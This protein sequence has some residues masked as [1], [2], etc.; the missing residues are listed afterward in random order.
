MTLPFVEAWPQLG[1]NDITFCRGGR[2]GN[3]VPTSLHIVGGNGR[4]GCVGTAP[5]CRPPPGCRARP[6]KKLPKVEAD[7]IGKMRL[8]ECKQ[9]LVLA[10]PSVSILSNAVPTR[11]GHCGGNGG[12][13][14]PVLGVETIVLPICNI[15]LY[16]CCNLSLLFPVTHNS[17]M[18]S[19]LP[20]KF[21]FVKMCKTGR[22]RFYTTNQFTDFTI[23]SR[24]LSKKIFCRCM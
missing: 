4:Q 12:P 18:I 21:Q 23:S 20:C 8:S 9:E 1:R 16:V 24:N 11:G 6:K 3:A 10:L 17:V 7:G 5:L 15:V 13:S 19:L 2:H 22:E 14:L